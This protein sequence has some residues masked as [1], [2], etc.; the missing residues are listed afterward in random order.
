MTIATDPIRTPQN[1]TTGLDGSRL[2]RELS[3]PMTI[4]AESA[5]VTKKTAVR[6][7]ASTA[8][9]TVSH[10]GVPSPFN[11]AKRAP[12]KEMVGAPSTIVAIPVPFSGVASLATREVPVPY[13]E[14]V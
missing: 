2:P 9:P 1:T 8:S 3:E 6:T 14:R 13:S 11:I 5:P 10:C 12:S 4:D 7:M